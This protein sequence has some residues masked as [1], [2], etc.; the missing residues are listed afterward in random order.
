[1]LTV[2]RCRPSKFVILAGTLCS[3]F[4]SINAG[5]HGRTLN[6]P[7]GRT[8][9]PSV[10]YGNKMVSRIACECSVSFKRTS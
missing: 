5:T 6:M 8:E 1:M 3:S 10:A 9:V 7:M 2:M 4:V